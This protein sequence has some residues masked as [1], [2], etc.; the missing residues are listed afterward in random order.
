M[1]SI[2]DCAEV[3][4]DFPDKEYMGA[5]SRET[6]FEVKVEADEVLLR[7]VRPAA[8]GGSSPYRCTTTWPTS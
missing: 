6:K 8:S 7:I 4:A 5:F 3:F 2:S 1:Q